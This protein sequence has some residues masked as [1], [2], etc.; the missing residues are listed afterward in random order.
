MGNGRISALS[1]SLRVEEG[2]LLKVLLVTL[3]SLVVLLLLEKPVR[4]LFPLHLQERI[5]AWRH[6]ISWQELIVRMSL[7]ILVLLFGI[8]FPIFFLR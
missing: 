1:V 6:G 3:A 8:L 5:E 2:R 4:L 7:A